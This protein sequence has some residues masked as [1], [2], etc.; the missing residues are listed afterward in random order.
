MTTNN[1]ALILG[2]VDMITAECPEV[3]DRK[4]PRAGRAD[5]FLKKVVA[6]LCDFFETDPNQLG[7]LLTDFISFGPTVYNPAKYHD[8]HH[9]A[10]KLG[11]TGL[12]CHLADQGGASVTS[13]LIQAH[14]IA[15]QNPEAVILIA[16]ADIPR[17]GFQ[18]K[19]DYALLNQGVTHPLYEEPYGGNLIAFYALLAK[20]QMETEG[21]TEEQLKAIVR[22]Y[23][24]RA[25]PNARAHHGGREL[26]ERHLNKYFAEPYSPP[27]IVV[28]TDHAV[29]TLVCGQSALRRVKKVLKLPAEPVYIGQGAT[30][31]HA[32]YFSLKGDLA[33]PAQ[34]TGPIVLARNGLRPEDIDYA[35]VYDCFVGMLISQTAAYF[36]LKQSVVADQLAGGSVRLGAKSIPV[37]R[38]GG[39]LNYQA[40]LMLSSAAGLMDVLS[41]YGLVP[42]PL[43]E[44]PAEKPATCLLGGNGGVD[45]INSLVPVFRDP[46]PGTAGNSTE[47]PRL[48]LNHPEKSTGEGELFLTTTVHFN[49]A[50]ALRPPYVLA[51]V[52]MENGF[53]TMC[54]L[55]RNGEL[56]KS[57]EGLV[58]GTNIRFQEMDGVVQ[59]V[60]E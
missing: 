32:T 14:A 33:S 39:I 7:N 34:V 45:S 16:G 43:F 12:H 11:L 10:E 15:R 17:S 25:L 6:K 40:A 41:N 56:L 48:T 42:D 53:F 35:W 20:A 57:D 5:L 58:S 51:L 13:S 60:L 38:G 46:P 47:P 49:A 23:R 19:A 28:A 8:T 52:K 22:Q 26:N 24:E 55:F 44:A 1:Q 18:G 2:A 27:M 36:G 50:G 54:N 59:G 37:N 9:K 3:S 30:A 29:A 31:H 4:K 21:I